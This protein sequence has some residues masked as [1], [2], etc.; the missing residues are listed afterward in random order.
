MKTPPW[1]VVTGAPSSGKTSLVNEI[2]ARGFQVIPEQSRLLI[3]RARTKGKTAEQVRSDVKEFQ[4][5][6]MN[7]KLEI[8]RNMTKDRII[9]FDTGIPTNMTYWQLHN[10]DT[11]RIE[12]IASNRYKKVFFLE[13]LKYKK[14]YARLEDEKTVKKL[15]KMILENYQ[16]FGYEI[17]KIPAI[18]L[19]QRVELVISNM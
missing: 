12:N 8:E 17:V 7:M 5:K 6:I 10:M 13:P 16:N 3:D 4:K 11:K 2:A 19:E 15:S 1:Y 18:P 9:F 14:D